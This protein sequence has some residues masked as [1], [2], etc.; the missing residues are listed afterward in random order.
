MAI[1]VIDGVTLPAPSELQ[2][3][4]MDLSKAERNARGLMIIERIATKQKLEVSYEFITKDDL[5]KVLNS[6]APIFFSV[7][8]EDPLT[9][10]NRTGTFYVGD[11]NIGVLDFRNGVPRYKDVSFSLVER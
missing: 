8:Y 3:G 9:G 10:T 6:V 1:L 4:I 11:R 5:R 7:Q 2:I